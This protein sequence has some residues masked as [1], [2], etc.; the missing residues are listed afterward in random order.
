ML[1][2]EEHLNDRD[3]LTPFFKSSQIFSLTSASYNCNDMTRLFVLC[4]YFI[5]LTKSIYNKKLKEN[6]FAVSAQSTEFH[7]VILV[8]MKWYEQLL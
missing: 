8:R 6:R 3:K 1:E 7:S 5:L 4:Y 2:L